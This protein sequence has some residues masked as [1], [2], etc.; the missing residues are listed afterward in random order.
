MDKILGASMLILWLQ[1]GWVSGQQKEKTAQQQ[2][3]QSPQSLIVQE[4]ENSTLN[5]TYEDSV[6]NYFPWY[7]KYPGEGPA[8]LIAIRSDK[9]TN[10]EGRFTIFLNKSTKEFS[11]TIAASQPG[12]SA[13]YF[14]AASAQCSA[15]PCSPY[16]NLQ[17]R[18]QP[19][20]AV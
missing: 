12:D 13:T 10:K 9:A 19:D 17:L 14:C 4:G 11:L 20:P 15:G 3:K 1:L 6:F 5:C 2:V 7:R 18:L 16:P 8:L